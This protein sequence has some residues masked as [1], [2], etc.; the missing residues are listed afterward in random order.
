MTSSQ[1]TQVG[2]VIALA[3]ASLFLASWTTG[4]LFGNP[5]VNGVELARWIAVP[6]HILLLIALV[7]IYLV[8]A[9]KTGALGLA[10]FLMAFSGTAI[11]IGYVVG[12][13]DVAI[14]EPQLGPIGGVLWL[15]G[16]LLLAVVT[17]RSSVLPGWAGVLWTIGAVVYATGV[18][19]GPQDVP[20]AAALIGAAGIAVGFGWAGVALMNLE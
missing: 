11:F 4:V 13:W 14:P 6:A 5:S 18:P 2:G 7:S 9:D 15:I 8:Q 1:L 20:G 17:W 10:A 16:L 12:G 19:D 3:G